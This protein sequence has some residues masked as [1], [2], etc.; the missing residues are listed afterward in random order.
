MQPQNFAK[1]IIDEY[2][3]RT[4]NSQMTCYFHIIDE[5]L[6]ELQGNDPMLWY[7]ELDIDKLV[8]ISPEKLRED[9][10]AYCSIVI[11]ETINE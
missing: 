6:S 10:Y 9:Y 4:F 7:S 8:D 5:Q 1:L 3:G 11:P 2:N